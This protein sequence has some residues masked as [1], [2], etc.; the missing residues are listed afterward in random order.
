MSWFGGG[1]DLAFD[2]EDFQ[3]CATSYQT[4][5]GELSEMKQQLCSLLDDLSRKGWTTE[6]GRTFSEMVAIDWGDTIDRYCDM[7]ET[8]SKILTRTAQEY[9]GL[10]REEI[11][12]IHVLS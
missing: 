12:T 5:A 11:D 3:E 1:T 8:L 7:L 10:I 4:I 2:L 9:D 6:A